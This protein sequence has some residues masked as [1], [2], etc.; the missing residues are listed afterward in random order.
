MT[1]TQKSFVGG[2]ALLAGAGLVGKV[3]GAFYRVFLTN[4]ITLQGMSIYSQP[5]TIYTILLTIST[6]G[7]PTAVSKMVSERVAVGDPNG[8]YAIFRKA[9][10]IL[11]LTGAVS[12]I[13]MIALS[14]PL[15]LIMGDSAITPAI[16]GLA[17]SVF[18]VCLISAYRGYFQG[19][20][21]ML[22]TAL[23]Q[24]IETIGKFIFGF[25]LATVLL[26][27]T[28][29]FVWGA[30]GA[31]LGVTISELCALVLM[32]FSHNT[33]QRQRPVAAGQLE[34][35]FLKTLLL[36]AIPITIGASMMPIVNLVDSALVINRLKSIGYGIEQARSLYAI[37]TG[38][39]NPLINMPTVISLGISTA[40]VPAISRAYSARQMRNVHKNVTLGL[41][42]ALLIGLPSA[43][44]MAMLSEPILTLLYHR[45]ATAEE[46]SLGG[47]VLA[48]MSVVI[49]SLTVTQTTTGILQGLGKPL[50]PVISL[51]IGILFKIVLNYTLI[52]VPSLHIRG[53][54]YAS[55]VCYVIGM[56]GNLY[57]L[58]RLLHFKARI[59]KLALYPF[60]STCVMAFVLLLYRY[61][62]LGHIGNT[63]YVFSG[64]ILGVI[65]YLVMAFLTGAI[66]MSDI[67]STS[68]GRKLIEK[69]RSRLQ[70]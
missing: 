42:L 15:A 69:L 62:A 34:P 43:V 4:I 3:L 5:Y 65:V 40:L 13:L 30:V 9:R 10:R 53:A 60:A 67:A 39:V 29:S 20:Q 54:A 58:H 68:I 35:D 17:P 14:Y 8:G 45:V 11:F 33:A 21:T 12:T 50:Y 64:L 26:K 22:P 59:L 46:L 7:L 6:A 63:V 19:M 2:A 48:L 37:I 51:G 1:K 18:L 38:F 52:A 41:R 31:I 70:E 27:T 32:V 57:F 56:V 23:S 61:V 36:I 47:Q 49:F 55:M 66:K 25:I 24:L 44:G 28:K 16:I